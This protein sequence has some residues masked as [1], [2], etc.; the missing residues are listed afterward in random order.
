MFIYELIS[1]LENTLS[2]VQQIQGFKLLLIVG[3]YSVGTAMLL[4]IQHKQNCVGYGCFLVNI[5][6]V[7]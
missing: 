4:I 3:L 2:V 5:K 7:S 6:Y 1:K